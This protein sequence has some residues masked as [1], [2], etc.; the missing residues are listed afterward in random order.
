VSPSGPEKIVQPDPL[1]PERIETARLIL[2]RPQSHEEAFCSELLLEAY[3]TRSVPLSPDAASRV[4]TYLVQ[5]WLH[6][7]FGQYVIEASG[8]PAGMCGVH[9]ARS[10]PDVWTLTG[11]ELELGYSLV[12]ATRGNGFATE[13]ASATLAL[14]FRAFPVDRIVARCDRENT[15][16]AAV[17][18]RIGMRD[19]QTGG[20]MQHFRIERPA[21]SGA[22]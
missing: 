3:R 7:G 20:E 8:A 2:R 21:G 22:F 12:P 15:H 17:L 10:F 16:S 11:A 13:A 19:T 14:A 5:H 6:Y 1:L 18:R 4:G 9:Y